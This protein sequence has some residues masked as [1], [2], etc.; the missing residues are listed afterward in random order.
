M[1]V[2]HISPSSAGFLTFT[3]NVLP[4]VVS[5]KGSVKSSDHTAIP[6]GLIIPRKVEAELVPVFNAKLHSHTGIMCPLT[7]KFVGVAIDAAVHLSAP[8]KVDVEH[9]MDEL[10]VVLKA[11][12]SGE[13]VSFWVDIFFWNCLL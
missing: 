10:K 8:F 2:Q 7:D 3:E 9:K 13:K 11:A 4:L 6:Y 12:S 5:L 1:D